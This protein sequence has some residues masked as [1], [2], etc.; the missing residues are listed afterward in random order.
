MLP[1]WYGFGSA[2]RAFIAAHPKQALKTLQAM[3]RDWPFFTTMLSNMDM[4]LAKSDIR[5]AQ[6]YSNLVS[7]R[8]LR[9]AVFS[10]LRAEW[11]KTVEALLAITGQGAVLERQSA[12]RALDSQPLSLCGSAQ[13][14]ADRIARAPSIRRQRSARAGGDSFDDERDRGGVAQ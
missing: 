10:R 3:C 1:G 7:D 8:T 2:V 14:H 13:P 12:A 6:L 4:V 11:T 9:E 5:I